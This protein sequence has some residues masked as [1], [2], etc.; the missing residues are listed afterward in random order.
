MLQENFPNLLGG[1]A[2]LVSCL[3]HLASIDGLDR[4]RTDTP[5]RRPDGV[6]HA[7][8]LAPVQRRGDGEAARE[9]KVRDREGRVAFGGLEKDVFWSGPCGNRRC[10]GV[11]RLLLDLQ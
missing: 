3:D 4:R 5:E 8:P 6:A 2:P 1:R 11:L 9:L 7:A 10:F